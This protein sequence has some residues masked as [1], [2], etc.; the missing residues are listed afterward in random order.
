MVDFANS[1]TVPAMAFGIPEPVRAFVENGVAQARQ[2]YD[3]LKD[4]AEGNNVAV[5]AAFGV[6]SKGPCCR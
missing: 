1:F 4:V 5:E 6:T 2:N 3:R